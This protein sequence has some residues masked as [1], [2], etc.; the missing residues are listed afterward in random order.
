MYAAA[1]I[2]DLKFDE[3][4]RAQQ[5]VRNVL[6]ISTPEALRTYRDGGSGWTV[7]E[8]LCHLRDFESVFLE[9][10]RLT[11]N[12]DFPDLPFPDP[13]QLALDHDYAK[14][15]A[16]PAFE[17]WVRRRLAFLE[18]LECRSEEDWERA[19]NHPT[20]G[21]FTLHQQLMLTTWH[22]INHLEQITRILVGKQ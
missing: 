8:V 11:V 18:Y 16:W 20:R 4:R 3:M 21:R 14:E 7:T 15:D 22:D 1:M 6:E 5:S 10:A 9:R 17:D 13:D 12:D 19:A 2:R